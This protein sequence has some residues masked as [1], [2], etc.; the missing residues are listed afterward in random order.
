MLTTKDLTDPDYVTLHCGEFVTQ[1]VS[2][3]SALLSG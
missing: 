3:N 2:F 1:P